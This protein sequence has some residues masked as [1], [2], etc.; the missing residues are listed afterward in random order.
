MLAKINIQNYG[1]EEKLDEKIEKKEKESNDNLKRLVASHTH[2]DTQNCDAYVVCVVGKQSMWLL[3]FG[4]LPIVFFSYSLSHS[5]IVDVDWHW[6]RFALLRIELS[7][8][9]WLLSWYTMYV[10]RQGIVQFYHAFFRS[11]V[12]LC[13]VFRE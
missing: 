11:A 1:Q 13:F 5:L 7:A 9:A 4:L 12:L 10:C 2:T 8:I 3:W 6:L